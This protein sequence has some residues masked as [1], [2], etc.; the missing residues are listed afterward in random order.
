MKKALLS[1]NEAVARGAYEA[2]VL[3]AAAYPGTPSTEILESMAQYTEVSAQ[4]CVN[5]KVAL[6]ESIG[7]AVSGA[8]ALAAMKHV[9]LNIAS[10]PFFTVSYT[11]IKAGLVVVSADDPGMFSSQNEQDNRRYAKFAK[12]PLLEPSNS[13]EA[14]ELVKEAF[15][16]S[17]KFDTPVL[18]RLTTRLSHS[19]GLVELEDREDVPLLDFDDQP[20]KYVVIPTNMRPRHPI[21]ERRLVQLTEYSEAFEGNRTEWRDRSIGVV[22]SGVSYQ[23]VR[24]AA[25]EVSVLKLAMSHPLPEKM[26]REFASG[27]EQLVAVEELDPYLEEQLRQMGLDVV[28]VERRS[29]CGELNQDIAYRV[30][31]DKEPERDAACGPATDAPPRP[32]VMCAGCPHRAVFHVLKK[33][34]TIIMGDIG[35]YTLAVLPPLEAMDTGVVMGTGVSMVAGAAKVAPDRRVCGVIGDSTF[36]HS[37]ITGLVDLVYNQSVAPIVILDNRTTAMT[38]H[39]DHPATGRTLQGRE[40]HRL[41]LAEIARA[42]GV[43]HV[44]RVDPL[45]VARLDEEVGAAFERDEPSVIISD[46]PCALLERRQYDFAYRIDEETCVRCDQCLKTGCPAISVR[47]E[48]LVIDEILCARC[49]LCVQVCKVEAVQRVDGR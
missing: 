47:E 45:D 20:R 17:E 30:I 9:G 49:G 40:T 5:E 22:T 8:R 24:E 11:G 38:G 23:Y 39:Q 34:K 41:D 26:V 13:Q 15:A 19:K 33:H 35:C 44:V 28:G 27:V 4:W 14:K 46:R 16:I 3:F 10:D 42:A 6:E 21:V 43:K 2:G 31:F 1:G 25:P 36:V 37:G 18:V 32:P 29:L 12:V 7:A 48:G